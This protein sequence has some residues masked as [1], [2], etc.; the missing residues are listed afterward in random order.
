MRITRS[1][2]LVLV[3][4]AFAAGLSLAQGSGQ[5]SEVSVAATV[6]SRISYQGVLK[7]GGHPV[8]GNRNMVFHFYTNSHCSGTPV[9]SVTKNNVSV[10]NGLFSVD[11]DV[12]QAK[13]N[14]QGLWLAVQVGG[15][16]IGCEEI[17]PAPY[18]LSLKPGAQ[19]KGALNNSPVLNVSNTGSGIAV[20]LWATSTNAAA[21]Y[22]Q[23]TN[24]IG[25][26]GVGGN[27]SIGTQRSNTGSGVGVKGYS[28]TGAAVYAAGKVQSSAKSYVWISG[29]SFV[30]NTDTDTTRWD[31]INNGGALIRR[32]AG[33]GNNW[34]Y[35]PITLP[36]VLYGQPVKLTK[37]TVYYKCQNGSK[38]YI[39]ATEFR[40]QT[41]ADSGATIVSSS[42][43]RTSNTAT[44][45]SLNL[46][47]NNTLSSAQG[48]LNLNLNLY[49]AD[50]TNYIL[51]GAI[52][53][54][55]EHD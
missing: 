32:S 27:N 31:M 3:M 19:V 1:V 49:F 54:E 15:T 50:T 9:Q 45:Y 22:G 44:S 25:L 29:N 13:F 14:G 18:A 55:L 38:N 34:V 42:T 4:L 46:T 12:N 39:T 17:L 10:A 28:A 5:Q 20:G 33:S 47:T 36:G 16:R 8:T 30:K 52:R 23:S 40:K 48:A 2:L 41:D 53:L 43:N 37:L 7:E 24:G 51:I 26:S 6:N 35:Y 11:L 21:V